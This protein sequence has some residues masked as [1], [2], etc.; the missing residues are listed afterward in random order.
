MAAGIRA[1]KQTKK[2]GAIGAVRLGRHQIALNTIEKLQKVKPARRDG[3]PSVSLVLGRIASHL[4]TC[5]Q[6]A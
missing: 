1:D 6:K 2:R 3:R 4:M 5:R